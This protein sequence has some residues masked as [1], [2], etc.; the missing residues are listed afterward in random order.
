MENKPWSHSKSKIVAAK[1][2]TE[3]QYSFPRSSLHLV[4]QK[5][6]A[7]TPQ[8]N[9]QED[10]NAD[11]NL[12]FSSDSD[13]DY[14]YDCTQSPTN[15]EEGVFTYTRPGDEIPESENTP[16]KTIE[17]FAE[18]LESKRMKTMKE[19][20]YRNCVFYE[21]F[22]DFPKDGENWREEDLRE[23][24]ADPPWESTK[25]GLGV[26]RAVDSIT[27]MIYETGG[28]CFELLICRVWYE[29]SVW[30]DLAHGKGVYVA[31]QGLVSIFIRGS[32]IDN[33]NGKEEDVWM[34]PGFT[35]Q[36]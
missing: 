18:V 34:A 3:K 14:D 22:F 29:G 24:W 17:R 19:D 12:P 5:W 11:T 27:F 6:Q 2:T 7:L 21:D 15:Q 8:T 10:P 16:E 31:E 36:F 23:F 30:D 25:P 4:V 9:P 13:S 1:I 26:T 33:N 32:K 28:I 35:N 20:E